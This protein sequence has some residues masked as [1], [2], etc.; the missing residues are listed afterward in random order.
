[1]YRSAVAVTF[2]VAAGNI[3]LDT[4]TG[5][6][7]F[8]ADGS[9]P[10][11]SHS[12][13]ASHQF[14]TTL[15]LA[16]VVGQKVYLSGITGTAASVLN[17]IA[18]TITAKSGAGP[19]TFTIG[20]TTTGLTASGGTAFAYPQAAEALTWAGQFD[21]PVRFDHDNLLWTIVDRSAGEY[22]YQAEQLRMVELR[23]A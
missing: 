20:T 17:G 3:S 9:Q 19:F 6:V 15:D 12:V 7:T 8:V 5:I 13:G 11:A 21:V 10:C 4:T 22:V 14:T 23:A 18:H 2:G 16:L 1:M